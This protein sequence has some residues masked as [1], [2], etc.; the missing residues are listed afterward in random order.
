MQR[1]STGSA[2]LD[3]VLRGGLIRDSITLLVGPPG[4][5]K[6]IL[7]ERCLFDQASEDRPGLY[8]STVSEPFDKLLRYGQSLSFFDVGKIG[9][10]VFYDDLGD[11][12]VHES[13]GAVSERISALVKE[14]RPGLVVIDSFKAL[15]AFAADEA[16][17]RRF[18]HEL[19][20][21]FTAL[22]VSSIWVGEYD[23]GEALSSPEFAVADTVIVLQGKRIAERSTRYLSIAKQRGSELLSGDHVYR[24]TRDG[25]QVFPRLADPINHDVYVALDER[26]PTG[27][28]ALDEYLEEGYWPG[29]TTLV[30]GPSGVGKTVMGLHFLFAGGSPQ[31]PGILL[32]LQENRTQLARMMSRFGWSIDD[33]RVR[34]LDRSPVD[35]YVDEL[36]YELIDC[37]DTV[38]ARRIVVDSF[39]DLARA[40]SDPTRLGDFTYSLV[41]RCARSG[42][43][44]MFTYETLELFGITR[45][46][47]YGIS[48]I[49]DNVVLLQLL[50]DGAEMKRAISVLKSRATAPST[51]IREFTI[52]TEGI[53]LGGPVNASRL[54][55]PEN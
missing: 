33:P 49:S 22:A 23:S 8:L 14:H 26:V 39:S 18:L 2:G 20:G 16:A 27:V 30:V 46:S 43:S 40:S 45:I 35:V 44:L 51:G 4:S 31:E 52:S 42:V 1:F 15:K 5:G 29:S 19:A 21:R 53:E 6:T 38:G 41:Q 48:N 37:L 24:V 25:L 17:F 10:A 11:V 36:V 54:Y 28:P 12:L 47:D 32:T 34:I 13:L 55:R 9:S 50:P 3:A 7:A